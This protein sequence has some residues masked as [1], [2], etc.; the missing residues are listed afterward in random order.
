MR[1]ASPLERARSA[2]EDQDYSTAA[3]AYEEY[4]A[5][6]PEEPEAEEARFRLADIY[7]IK[8][9]Q[10]ER[11]RD[12]YAALLE[13]YPGSEHDYDA[14]RRLAEVNVELRNPVE[15]IAQ[16]ERL[17]ADHPHTGER[18]K[19]RVAIADL[20]FD[21]NDVSQAEIEY[22]RVIAG[23][24][25]DELTEHSLLRMASIYRKIRGQHER[26]LE[27][28]DRVAASTPDPVVRRQALYSLSEAYAEL[29]RF[30]KAIATLGRIDDPAE[31]EY[32]ARRVAEL[33]R[34]RREHQDTP[35]VNW[36]DGKADRE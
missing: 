23:A 25:Y 26:A 16:Y 11:A 36:S 35:E 1:S 6:A 21:S 10:Y 15:A 33:E 18:R 17:V 2:A 5:E 24:P 7:Y 29:F 14:R 4:L 19:V 22:K 3:A 9:K 31:A 13:Q 12:H 8:L 32:V 30:D 34:Q 20:Y 28:Y 27:L